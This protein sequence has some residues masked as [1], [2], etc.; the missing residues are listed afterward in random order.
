MYLR[1]EGVYF[2][3]LPEVI[4]EAKIKDE[5]KSYA[6]DTPCEGTFQRFFASINKILI[7]AGRL[8]TKLSFYEVLRL[9]GYFLCCLAT[10]IYHFYK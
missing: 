9:S 10:C 6:N 3:L 2:F 1:Q 7:F 5:V 8:G 4:K